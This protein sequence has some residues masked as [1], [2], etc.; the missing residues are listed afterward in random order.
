MDTVEAQAEDL[1]RDMVPYTDST[2]NVWDFAY[3]LNWQ[4]L[5]D[6]ER[7]KKY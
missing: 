6:D 7:V 5:I 2:G 3:G 1:A 4:G